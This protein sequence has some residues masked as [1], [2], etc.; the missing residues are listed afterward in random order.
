MIGSYGLELPLS[1]SK[2]GHPPGF[3]PAAAE[4]ALEAARV[5]LHDLS[6]SLPGTRVEVKRWG[7]ALHFRAAPEVAADREVWRRFRGLA[8]GLGLNALEGRLVYEMKPKGIADKGWTMGYL[9]ERLQPSAATFTGDDLGDVPAWDRLRQLAPSLPT[10]AV[11]VGSAE[12]SAVMPSVCDLV[13]PDRGWIG[14]FCEALLERA[15]ST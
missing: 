10:L 9:V 2:T 12:A 8:L 5:K 11:G 4:A 15:E 14:R 7:L 3:E 6:K 13:L 1:L